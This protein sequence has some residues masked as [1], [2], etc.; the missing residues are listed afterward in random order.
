MFIAAGSGYLKEKRDNDHK[1]IFDFMVSYNSISKVFRLRVFHGFNQEQIVRNI[2]DK[3]IS[4][5]IKYLNLVFDEISEKA[6][7]TLQ[8]LESQPENYASYA[9][10]DSSVISKELLE[11]KIVDEDF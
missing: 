1:G 7:V 8:M 11:Q 3:D 2:I 9:K 6:L 10:E 4:R 5:I